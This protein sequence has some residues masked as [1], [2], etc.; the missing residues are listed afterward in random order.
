MQVVVMKIQEVL[1]THMVE[2]LQLVELVIPA[3]LE[4][5]PL[6]RL[7]SLLALETHGGWISLVALLALLGLLGWEAELVLDELL[8]LMLYGLL[9][10]GDGIQSLGGGFV[11]AISN[12]LQRGTAKGCRE[13][14]RKTAKQRSRHRRPL[15]Y[16]Q[17]S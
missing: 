6:S 9:G 2:L 5:S 1:G 8:V 17:H 7:S 16:Q 10:L 14:G 3:W 11:K 15:T 4:L 12:L 13:E